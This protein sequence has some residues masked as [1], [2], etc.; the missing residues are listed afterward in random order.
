MAEVIAIGSHGTMTILDPPKRPEIKVGDTF[1]SAGKGTTLEGEPT[2]GS[3][4]WIIVDKDTVR[5]E[6]TTQTKG[7]EKEPDE[8]TVMKRQ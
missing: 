4:K 5:W 1:T 6:M 8:V 2:T 7:G 3:T